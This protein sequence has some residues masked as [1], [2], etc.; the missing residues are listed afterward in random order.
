MFG[1][2]IPKWNTLR[3]SVKNLFNESREKIKMI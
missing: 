3:K 1:A 2:A